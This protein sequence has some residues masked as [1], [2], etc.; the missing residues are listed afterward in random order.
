MCARN[1][2]KTTRHCGECPHDIDIRPY[3]QAFLKGL[4]SV[5][6]KES[7]I[8]ELAAEFRDFFAGTGSCPNW[9]GKEGRKRGPSAAELRSL[10]HAP[11][12]A[13]LG[14]PHGI[15]ACHDPP[16]SVT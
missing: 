14:D 2:T 16:G 9:V 1:G 6:K 11:T 5:V 13:S 3:R 15:P 10:L 7:D 12:Q 4:P 8:Q